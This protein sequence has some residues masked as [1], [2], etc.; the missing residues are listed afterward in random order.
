MGTT[1]ECYAV[2]NKCWTQYPITQ[3]LEGHQPPISYNLHSLT[4]S[5]MFKHRPTSKDLLI[6]VLYV[7]WP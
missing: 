3:Q 4:D 6:A 2:F 5:Y 7:L 1:Q